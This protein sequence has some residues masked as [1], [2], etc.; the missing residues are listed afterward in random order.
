MAEYIAEAALAQLVKPHDHIFIPGSS[1]EPSA[2]MSA[3]LCESDGTKDLR[4]LTSYV[5]GINKLEIDRFAPTASVSGLFMQPGLRDA[6]RDGRYRFLPITYAGFVRH[7]QEN[8]ELDLIVIQTSPPDDDGLCSLGPAVE[9]APTAVK[10]SRRILG[11]LN[12]RTPRVRGAVKIPYSH[13]DYVCE[14]D[15]ELPE[16]TTT[17]D[18]SSISVARNVASLIDD[19]SIVQI[20]LGRVPAALSLQLSDRR[21]LRFHSGMLSDGLIDLVKAGA[22]DEDCIHSCCVLVGSESLY[23][24]AADYGALQVVGCEVTHNLQTL[25]AQDRFISVNSALE[26][27]LFG[28]CNL[29]HAD[30]RSVS[31]PGGAPDF[32][33]GARLSNGGRSIVALCATHSAGTASRIVPRL[34]ERSI[35]T[36]S[37]VDVDYVVTDFGVARLVGASVHERAKALVAIAAPEFREDLSRSWRDIAAWL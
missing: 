6:Q 21:K 19:G 30:G 5:P 17:L 18:D 1:G 4:I 28:Q 37:R 34:G 31:G 16:Y 12:H 15:S 33:R 22:V 7:L 11:L 27:D 3:L 9:F 25:S 32:A 23:R 26:V 8:V 13:F 24:W 20:G 29:E 36:L 14:V 10:K 2:F 35:G